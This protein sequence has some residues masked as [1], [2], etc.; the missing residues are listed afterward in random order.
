M[1]QLKHTFGNLRVGRIEGMQ[2]GKGFVFVTIQR[3]VQALAK[4]LSGTTIRQGAIDSL[5]FCNQHTDDVMP[6]VHA[7]REPD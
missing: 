1:L 7:L 3:E 4:W 6:R 2:I 5:A